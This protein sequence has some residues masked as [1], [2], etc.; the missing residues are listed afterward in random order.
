[1]ETGCLSQFYI[2]S[3][4]ACIFKAKILTQPA[5]LPAVPVVSGTRRRACRYLLPDLAREGDTLPTLGL[6]S[7]GFLFDKVY[8]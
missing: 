2:T 6:S 4:Q 3:S 7:E 5:G 8:S 1:M